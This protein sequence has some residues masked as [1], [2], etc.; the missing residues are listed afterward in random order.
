MTAL[1]PFDMLVSQEEVEALLPDT[2]LGC[3]EHLF[4]QHAQDVARAKSLHQQVTDEHSL[5]IVDFFFQ[6]AKDVFARYTPKPSDVF[7]LAKTRKHI[8]AMYWDRALKSTSIYDILPANRKREWQESITHLTTPEFSPET[9][10]ETID[11]LYQQLPNFMAERVDGLYR[12]LSREHVTNRPE[13]FSARGIFGYGYERSFGRLSQAA[14]NTL[15]DL[16]NTIAILNG[17]PQYLHTELYESMREGIRKSGTGQWFD[18]LDGMFN[19][20]VYLKGTVHVEI[21]EDYAW[22]LNTLLGMANP[23]TIPEKY[24]RPTKQ[25]KQNRT[26]SYAYNTIDRDTHQLFIQLENTRPIIENST[27]TY[28]LKPTS[29]L[30]DKHHRRVFCNII[31]SIGGR[32][33]PENAAVFSYDASDVFTRLVTTGKL[34]E[35][36]TYQFYP[37]PLSIAEMVIKAAEITDGQTVLEPSAG[38]GGLADVIYQNH[39]NAKLLCVEISDLNAAVLVAKK[40]QTI[41]DDFLEYA[42]KT[43]DSFDRVIMN[44]PYSMG[45]YKAHLAAAANLIKP[46]GIMVAVLPASCM[47]MPAPAGF[48]ALERVGTHT[49]HSYPNTAIQVCIKVFRKIATQSAPD[50]GI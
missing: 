36:T 43:T 20:R 30:G 44:P 5:L 35:R 50:N 11:Q 7:N 27:Y 29:Q 3:L 39:P 31:E 2:N 10:N 23:G 46:N 14:Q 19:I 1:I 18:V 38:Q 26:Y 25:P 33:T 34:P 47:Y 21:H 22:K 37:T 32:L 40:H 48:S 8:D 12:A 24:R 6:A 17:T 16:A 41:I 28:Q 9:V 4:G 15:E 13:G 49:P 45:R 42:K